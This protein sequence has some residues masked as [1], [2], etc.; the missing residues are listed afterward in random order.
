MMETRISVTTETPSILQTSEKFRISM[1]GSDLFCLNWDHFC[2]FSYIIRPGGI[3]F[4]PHYEQLLVLM[5]C[6]NSGEQ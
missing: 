3:T 5:P 4:G 2:R 1:W 6:S